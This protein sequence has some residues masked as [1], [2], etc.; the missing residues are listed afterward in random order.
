MNPTYADLWYAK[1]DLLYNTDKVE[2]SFKCYRRA[3]ELNPKDHECWFDFGD[4]ALHLG[5]IPA[6][7]YAF[8]QVIAL[9]PEWAEGYY[10]LAKIYA[11]EDR[12]DDAAKLLAT[13]L[14]LEPKMESVYEVDF[15]MFLSDDKVRRLVHAV[16]RLLA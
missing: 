2:E 13:A 5:N 7:I 6:A 1:A 4:T 12:I 10:A 8:Q 16:M 11:A 3:L 9:A 15:M 14:K